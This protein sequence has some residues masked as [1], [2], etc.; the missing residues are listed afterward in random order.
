M[1]FL[2]L[3]K[4]YIQIFAII[5]LDRINMSPEDFLGKGGQKSTKK[6]DVL[7]ELPVMKPWAMVMATTQPKTLEGPIYGTKI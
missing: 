7:F 6:C 3:I 5:I 4:A 2:F 1:L